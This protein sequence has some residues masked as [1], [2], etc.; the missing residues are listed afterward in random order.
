MHGPVPATFD[1]GGVPVKV[2]FAPDHTPEL[3]FMKQM[4]K[5]R[6]KG[7]IWFAIFTFAG[8]SGIDDTMLALAR[9]GVK[10]RG[11]LDGGQAAQG[12]AAPRWLQHKNIELRV[13]KKEGSLAGLRKVHHKLMVIDDRIVVAGSFN[14]TAPANEYND[15]NLFILGSPHVEA[16]G[17]EVEADPVRDLALH[18]RARDPAAVRAQRAVRTGLIRRPRSAAAGSR[19]ARFAAR[20]PQASPSPRVSLRVPLPMCGVSTT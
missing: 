15:E 11:V 8:S 7:E 14:Y 19:A 5:V 12:W 3:E 1:L 6:T 2:L 10:I 20:R 16:G 4:L 18:A 13:P 9:G 17:V